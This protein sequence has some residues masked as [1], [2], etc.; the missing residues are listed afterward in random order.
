[1]KNN[2]MREI[3]LEKVTLNC[4]TGTEKDKL[5]KSFRLLQIISGEKP[6]KIETKKRIPG[7]N[8]RPGLEIGCK[9]TIRKEKARELLK[10]LLEGIGNKLK[11]KQI[12]PGSFAFGIKEYLQIPGIAYQRDIGMLGLEVCATLIRA[13]Y[14]VKDR[15][16]KRGKLPQRQRITKE[17]TIKFIEDNFKVEIQ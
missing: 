9:V 11:K 10:R 4:G 1:M 15:K 8:V 14:N 2:I 7:F 5:E 16:I 12:I 3:K 6:I 13:G 17:E